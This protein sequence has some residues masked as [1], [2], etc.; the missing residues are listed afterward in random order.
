[1]SLPNTQWRWLGMFRGSH[2][3]DRKINLWKKAFINTLSTVSVWKEF[4]VRVHVQPIVHWLQS[5][6]GRRNRK[7]QV[8]AIA[9][10]VKGPEHPTQRGVP[11]LLG[12]S[13]KRFEGDIQ[14]GTVPSSSSSASHSLLAPNPAQTTCGDRGTFL[15]CAWESKKGRLPCCWQLLKNWKSPPHAWQASGLEA[16]SLSITLGGC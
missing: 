7:A 8:L 14:S 16:S 11:G 3:S 5:L 15:Q 12:C 10:F 4:L 9:H 1:M 13:G 6:L 2:F